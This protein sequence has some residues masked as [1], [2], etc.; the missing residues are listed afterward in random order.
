MHDMVIP[1]NIDEFM[2]GLLIE[3]VVSFFLEKRCLIFRIS[4]FS[5]LQFSLL[6]ISEYKY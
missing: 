6:E 1:N 2:Y 4:S 3:F 5:L